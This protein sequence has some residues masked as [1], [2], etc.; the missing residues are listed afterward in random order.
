MLQSVSKANPGCRSMYVMDTRPKVCKQ[1]VTFVIDLKGYFT[2][3]E[4]MI[5]WSTPPP[6]SLLS[7]PPWVM[8]RHHPSCRCSS[9]GILNPYSTFLSFCR[10]SGTDQS[11]CLCQRWSLRI[12]LSRPGSPEENERG[13]QILGLLYCCMGTDSSS[14]TEV[15]TM[16]TSEVGG[17]CRVFVPPS[18]FFFFNLHFKAWY[19]PWQFI[20]SRGNLK[21]IR[22]WNCIS[23]TTFV[24]KYNIGP[25]W[26]LSL[27]TG[28]LLW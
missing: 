21:D 27:L 19:K 25:H 3:L 20:Q 1:S 12:G 2:F 9:P 6:N 23:V 28:T 11:G 18:F 26:L 14:P 16:G 5:R 4:K 22:N 17:G 15:H 10:A 13:V 24:V 8:S 7:L